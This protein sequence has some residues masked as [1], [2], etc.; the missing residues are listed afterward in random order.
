[1]P[2]ETGNYVLLFYEACLELELIDIDENRLTIRV[3]L[4]IEVQMSDVL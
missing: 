4:E 1:M 2:K 3:K